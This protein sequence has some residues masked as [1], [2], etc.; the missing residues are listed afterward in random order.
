MSPGYMSHGEARTF[1]GHLD[2]SVAIFEN[3]QGRTLA[4]CVCIRVN[5][6]EILDEL[7]HASVL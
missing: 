6:V 7:L 5:E 4:G 2:D 3:E 1:C